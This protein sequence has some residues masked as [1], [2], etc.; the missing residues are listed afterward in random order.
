MTPREALDFAK[1]HVET[2]NSHVLDDILDLYTDDVELSSP[3]AKNLQGDDAI[4][5]KSS[6]RDY[7]SRALEKYPTLEFK[8]RDVL[9]GADSVT[10]YFESIE[11]KIVADVLVLGED[12]KI[13][14]VL[15]HYSCM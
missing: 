9:Y 5:G 6:L 13:R 3:L 10:I 2:W 11:G 14:K 8:L 15:A 4:V 7:F 1:H 12:R